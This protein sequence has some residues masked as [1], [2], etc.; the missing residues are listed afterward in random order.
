[1]PPCGR[2]QSPTQGQI[3]FEKLLAARPI[4]TTNSLV[5][6]YLLPGLVLDFD[7]VKPLP[8][9]AGWY[10]L[11]RSQTLAAGVAEGPAETRVSGG[12]QVQCSSCWLS[13][14]PAAE[15]EETALPGAS[16]S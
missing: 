14:P 6:S 15:W 5:R 13:V 7:L 9:L 16:S 12:C 10:S 2:G 1:M 11:L 3:V 4:Q 8:S